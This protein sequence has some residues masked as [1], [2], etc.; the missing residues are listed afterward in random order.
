MLMYRLQIS[1]DRLL[2]LQQNPTTQPYELNSVGDFIIRTLRE[3]GQTVSQD[4]EI[5]SLVDHRHLFD[6]LH[7]MSP[8]LPPPGETEMS[9]SKGPEWL[10]WQPALLANYQQ[11]M[12]KIWKE[13]S[14]EVVCRT[15]PASTPKSCD[16]GHSP[17]T[18]VSTEPSTEAMEV[19]ISICRNIKWTRN[20]SS[21]F[22]IKSLSSLKH[23]IVACMVL[24][25]DQSFE[26]NVRI[27]EEL[28]DMFNWKKYLSQRSEE[29]KL[30]YC[31]EVAGIDATRRYEAPLRT[32]RGGFIDCMGNLRGDIWPTCGSCGRPQCDA[33]KTERFD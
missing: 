7:L 29:S 1:F 14:D 22:T 25:E 19:G 24:V 10:K 26:V 6:P 11:Q 3:L 17:V 23:L 8:A 13:A 12:R 21:I 20:K 31:F 33:L 32:D 16:M 18:E 2:V 27:R 4:G 9:K 28:Q 15:S 5:R 30:L